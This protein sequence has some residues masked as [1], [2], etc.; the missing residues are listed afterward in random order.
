MLIAAAG[1]IVAGVIAVVAVALRFH[2]LGCRGR[3]R[4]RFR[5]AWRAACPVRS[6][7]RTTGPP[8]STSSITTAWARRASSISGLLLERGE[9]LVADD[10][11]RVVHDQSLGFR[12]TTRS[13]ITPTPRCPAFAGTGWA[14]LSG[15]ASAV[16]LSCPRAGRAV[17]RDRD[18]Q[19]LRAADRH[20]HARRRVAAARPGRRPVPRLLAG[21]PT[22]RPSSS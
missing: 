5:P 18:A 17:R 9:I 11:I 7:S 20:R 1:V 16:P 10:R 14:P 3:S 6:T 12:G 22:A 15:S 13:T 21:P 8:S 19:V 2:C 4:R